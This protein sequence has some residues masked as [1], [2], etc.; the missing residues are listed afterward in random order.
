M[1]YGQQNYLRGLQDEAKR[2][3]MRPQRVPESQKSRTGGSQDHP[4]GSNIAPRGLSVGQ[5]ERILD[6]NEVKI[7][8]KIEKYEK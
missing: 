6:E 8:T 5:I 3:P 2:V 7:G 4:R 1:P